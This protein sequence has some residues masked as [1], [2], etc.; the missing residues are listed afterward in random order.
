SAATYRLRQIDRDGRFTYTHEIEAHAAAE[1]KEFALA[2]NYPNPFNPSTAFR[3][4][5][6]SATPVRLIVYDLLG[7]EVATVVDRMME[8]GTH[9]V[10]WNASALSS[11]VY[12]YRLA[13]GSFTETKKL[14]LQK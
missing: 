6:P 1:P 7:R 14:T 3:F 5:V 2:Q 9:T 8:A 11:G 4:T 12:V 13:A 10:Q